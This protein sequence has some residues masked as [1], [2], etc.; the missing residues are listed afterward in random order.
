MCSGHKCD[1]CALRTEQWRQSPGW[2]GGGAHTSAQV[3]SKGLSEMTIREEAPAMQRTGRKLLQV[4]AAACLYG[5]DKEFGVCS[6]F[7]V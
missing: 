6:K 2:G 1:W 4:K 7:S 3:I 5:H